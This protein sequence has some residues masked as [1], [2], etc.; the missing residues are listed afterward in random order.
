MNLKPDEPLGADTTKRYCKTWDAEAALRMLLNNLHPDVARNW[1]ELIVYGGSGRAARNWKEFHKIVRALKELEPDETLC[2]QSGKPVY[3]A[4]T[5]KEA[6]RVILANSNLVGDWATQDYFDKLDRMGL[7][8][9]GQMTAGSWI[10][11]GTQGILQGTYETF[12][13]AGK[14]DFNTDSLAG[15]LILTAG[16]G[17]MSGAQ[18]MAATLNDAVIL[19][20]EVK[21]K[22]IARKVKEDYCDKMTD[23]LDEAIDWAMAAKKDREPL[24]IGLVGNAADIH[25]ELVRRKVIPDILTDQTSAHEVKK[26]VP[27]GY[28][29]NFVELLEKGVDVREG[30]YVRESLKSMASH[31]KAMIDMQEQGAVVFDYGNALRNQVELALNIAAGQAPPVGGMTEADV[32]DLKGHLKKIGLTKVRNKDGGYI[33]P[34]FVLR[35]I[36][37]LFC[38]GKGPF[39]WACLSGDP[40][41]LLAIDEALISAFPDDKPLIRWI[42]RA[43]KTVPILGLPTRICWLAYGDRAKF[44]R[45]IND[46]IKDGK[47]TAPVVIGRDHLDC[48]SVAS[49]SRETEGMKDGSDAISDWPLL[50]F[51]LN[52]VNGASWVSF[53]HGGG[54][55]IGKSLHAGMVIVADG[56]KERA[57]R[58]ERVL[59]VDPGTGIARHVD[60]GYALALD[61]SKKKDVKIPK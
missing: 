45:I 50:N 5:H 8:M 44:G 58:L 56:T 42:K 49:P 37:P 13:A 16:M 6:P 21:K 57:K 25:P 12:A 32:A 36:R 60:A 28:E 41:D 26:Y 22:E 10:Y 43:Q 55:G 3:I 46:L 39:R 20:V 30:E 11:I 18:P 31:V 23:D 34:G 38:E 7:M 9:Y 59:T 17:A 54:V 19:D 51:A 53:H 27:S 33:Y 15:K 35:Y 2:I 40:D 4:P 52:A 24:S 61:V 14:K 48:G 1:E 29:A 47:V